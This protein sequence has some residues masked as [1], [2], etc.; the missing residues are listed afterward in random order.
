MSKK[1]LIT[2][3]TY[4][5]T[6]PFLGCAFLTLSDL[7]LNFLPIAASEIARA[8]GAVI[9]SFIAGSHWGLVLN[10]KAYLDILIHSNIAALLAWTALLIPMQSGLLLLTGLFIYLYLIDIVR[11]NGKVID[12]DYLALRRNAS[13]VVVLSL[14]A[15]A[16]M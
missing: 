11:L 9:L 4:A 14:L 6:L 3:L 7:S 15:I 1:T 12:K 10:Q 16:F 8:Y 5:G 13:G 2:A